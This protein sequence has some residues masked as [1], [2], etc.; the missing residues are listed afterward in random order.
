ML[1]GQS[2]PSS[3]GTGGGPT[4][5]LAELFGAGLDKALIQ[6]CDGRLQ[7]VHWFRTDWQRGGALTGYGQFTDGQAE[8]PIVAKLPVPPRELRW[9]QRLQPEHHDA[10]QVVP[11]LLAC[12]V[13]LGG[14]DMAWIVMERLTHGPLGPAWNGC[15]I[16]LLIDAC[17]RFYCAAE[18]VPVDQ[19]P[20][21]EDWPGIIQRAR[22]NLRNQALPDEQQWNTAIK[23][24]QRK[25]DAILGMWNAREVS[26]WCHGDLHL[27]NAMTHAAPPDGPAMLFDLAQV[28]A[29]HWIEDA[30]YFE[31]LYWGREERLCGRKP[32]KLI[33]AQ[34]RAMNLPVDA[35][36]PTLAH[37]RRVLLAASVPAYMAQAGHRAHLAGALETLDQSLSQIKAP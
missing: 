34:R 8:I 25:L 27:G 16:D 21:L 4:N 29:G 9:M 28:H 3:P 24:L 17:V 37:I 18:H 13:E 20:R 12:G 5:N 35:D 31:H 6:A 15:E 36:W 33:A 22:S 11:R 32:A 1:S 19:P 14:Y 30:I 10:S 2:G 26:Y 23:A 7:N